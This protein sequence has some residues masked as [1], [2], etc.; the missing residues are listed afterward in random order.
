MANIWNQLSKLL[1]M[2]NRF[3]NSKHFSSS[4]ATIF[5]LAVVIVLAISIL[6]LTGW[7]LNIS[8]LKNVNL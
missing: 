3:L 4:H 7:I 5:I 8:W 2:K 6:D 1:L